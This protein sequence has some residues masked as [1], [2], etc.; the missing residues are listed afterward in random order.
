MEARNFEI[1]WLSLWRILFFGAFVV[2][3]FQGRQILLGLFLAI[4]ISSGLEVLVDFL[5]RHG[6]ARTLGVI[7]IFLFGLVLVIVLVYAVLPLAVVE[8]NTIFSGLNNSSA[9]NLLKSLVNIKTS[10]SMGALLGK[11]SAQFFS[12]GVSPLDFFSQT[13]G[14]FGLAVAVL[15]SSFYLTLSRDGV[16]RFIKTVFPP[17]YEKQA[18]KIYE[19]SRKKIGF[20]FQTQLLLSLVMVVLVWSSL[21]VLGVKHAFLVGLL[22]G[23]F[24]LMPFVG[25]ILSGAV[26]VT[27]A[28]STSAS[29][30]L[31]TLLVFLAL[32][33]FESHVL[34]PILMR[35]TVGLHPVIVIIS[36][37][38]GA[39]VGGFLGLL[40]AVPAAAV[41]QEVID[42]WSTRKRAV[43]EPVL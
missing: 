11:L 28:L 3:L 34:V 27:M 21:F 15:V 38:I 25:P 13:L 5:E 18:L 14:S 6:V 26:A 9:N 43:L 1:S 2:V 22:A 31:Y 33:Q 19:R 41:F 40:I 23:I 42:E 16:E 10:Q 17:D 20:W 32:H 8:L 12:G 35:R 37:L 29:L 30:A 24:E 39:E 4:I 7:L 36:L